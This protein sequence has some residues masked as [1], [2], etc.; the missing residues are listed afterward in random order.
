[1]YEN[2]NLCYQHSYLLLGYIDM[3]PA[4]KY[5]ESMLDQLLNDFDFW[6]FP[7]L[8]K[9]LRENMCLSHTHKTHFRN[10]SRGKLRKIH[11]L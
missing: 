11:E 6:H 4:L 2:R 9:F 3:Y 1:M 7:I 8:G 10:L 5:I